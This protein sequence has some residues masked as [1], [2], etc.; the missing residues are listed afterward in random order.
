M[1]G[2]VIHIAIATEYIKKNKEKIKNQQDF[3]K[4]SIAPDVNQEFTEILKHKSKSH[5]GRWGKSIVKTNIDRF[6]EDKNV[7]INSDYWKGYFIHL[8]SD[9]YFYSIDF[10]EEF[11]F[12]IKNNDTFYNDYDNLN[13]TLLKRYNIITINKHLNKYMR[14]SDNKLKYLDEDKIIRFIEK[15]SSFDLQEKIKIIKENKMEGLK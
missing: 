13:K 2:L 12:K 4:G 11:K 9:Y 8:L 1:P 15:I 3:I 10:K 14:I 7:N 6:L 5:Y